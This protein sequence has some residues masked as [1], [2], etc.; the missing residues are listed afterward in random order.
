[1]LA[2][3]E[4][5]KVDF[6]YLI[7]EKSGNRENGQFGATRIPNSNDKKMRGFFVYTHSDP[8]RCLSHFSFEGEVEMKINAKGSFVFIRTLLGVLHLFTPS[9]ASFF[10][11]CRR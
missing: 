7:K 3:L 2:F 4:G 10:G 1:M 6:S 5:R 11:L 8:R 9:R